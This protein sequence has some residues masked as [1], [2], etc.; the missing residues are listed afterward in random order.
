MTSSLLKHLRVTYISAAFL[1][2][3]RSLWALALSSPGFY[4]I[5]FK[6]FTQLPQTFAVKGQVVNTFGLWTYN[7]CRNHSALSLLWENGPG[8][9]VSKG[10]RL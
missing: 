3:N 2:I 8:Q 1:A 10:A 9:L 7:L 5:C 4:S 6:T